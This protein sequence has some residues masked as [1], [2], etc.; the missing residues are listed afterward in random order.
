[1]DIEKESEKTR[2]MKVETVEEVE[3]GGETVEGSR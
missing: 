1:L 3:G 2:Q